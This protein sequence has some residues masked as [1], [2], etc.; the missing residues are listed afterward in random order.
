[1]KKILLFII[2]LLFFASCSTQ[3]FLTTDNVR[4]YNIYGQRV[5]SINNDYVIYFIQT[6]E[7]D[8]DYPC[9]IKSINIK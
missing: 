3:S 2:T 5:E 4:I 8:S 6:I 7:K 9:W 1:M